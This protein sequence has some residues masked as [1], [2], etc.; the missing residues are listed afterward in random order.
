MFLVLI[1]NLLE[2]SK[3]ILVVT[4]VSSYYSE[5]LNIIFGAPQGSLLGPLLLNINIIDLFL[6][7]HYKSDGT[8]QTTLTHI[9]LGT[10]F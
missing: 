3:H 6:I 8:I 7:K 5:I 9:I 10:D 4:K 2:S 1:S